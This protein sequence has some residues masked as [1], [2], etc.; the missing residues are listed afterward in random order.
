[1]VEAPDVP[2]GACRVELHDGLLE[3]APAA[4]L[5]HLAEGLSG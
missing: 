5:D 1:V 2:P 4:M 3:A